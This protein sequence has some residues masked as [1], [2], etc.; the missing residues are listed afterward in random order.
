MKAGYSFA[1]AFAGLAATAQ[2]A[3][4]GGR[5]SWAPWLA[6]AAFAV[7]AMLALHETMHVAPGGMRRLWMGQTAM[8]CPFIILLAAAPTFALTFWLLRRAAPTRLA[9]TGAM[10]GAFAGGAGAATW[11]LYCAE[12]TAAFVLAWYTLGV[13]VCAG[14]GALLGPRLLR[15]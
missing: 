15:W 14:L 11:A 8:V 5:L 1:L 4:P 12:S 2:L 13:A 10:A 6:L 3:R 7:V 9:L